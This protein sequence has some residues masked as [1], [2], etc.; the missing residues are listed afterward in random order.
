[1]G[2]GIIHGTLIIIIIMVS[3]VSTAITLVP[4]PKSVS[5]FQFSPLKDW[6]GLR[7]ASDG[8]ARMQDAIRLHFIAKVFSSL[9]FIY[10]LSCEKCTH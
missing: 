8:V 6:R 4:N 7:A 10:F 3:F 2:R 9:S 1:M 5:E